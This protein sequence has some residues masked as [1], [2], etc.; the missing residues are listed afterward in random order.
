MPNDV[1][2]GYDG[3]V[4]VRIAENGAV[5]GVLRDPSQPVQSAR[6]QSSDLTHGRPRAHLPTM[7][8]LLLAAL[9]LLSV[10]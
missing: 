3:V 4:K 2:R 7:F 9:T 6:L 1:A 10:M 5:L 8:R